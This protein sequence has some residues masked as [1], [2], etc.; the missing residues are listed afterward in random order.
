MQH[1]QNSIVT[2]PPRWSEPK[3][4]SRSDDRVTTSKLYR[5]EKPQRP[6]SSTKSPPKGSQKIGNLFVVSA[7]IVE[8]CCW[9]RSFDAASVH[10]DGL[11]VRIGALLVLVYC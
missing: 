7:E 6:F 2:Q 8:R 5:K 9:R 10:M 11:V 3:R 1:I 4:E